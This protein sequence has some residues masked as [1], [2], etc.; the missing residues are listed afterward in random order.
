MPHPL[1]LGIQKLLDHV[2]QGEKSQI[3]PSPASKARLHKQ[4]RSPKQCSTQEQS[5]FMERDKPKH[6][7]MKE[8]GFC[9]HCLNK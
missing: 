7:F 2:P 3:P 1:H 9:C 5:S 6:L 4:T 8:Y